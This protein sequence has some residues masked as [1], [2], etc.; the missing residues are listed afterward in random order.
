[1]TIAQNH[2]QPLLI[3]LNN[4]DLQLSPEQFER[5]RMRNP[6]LYLELTKDGKLAVMSPT[7]LE[8]QMEASPVEKDDLQ[9]NS[10]SSHSTDR[11]PQLTP[12]E[13]ARRVAMV[14]KSRHNRAQMWN[15]LTPEERDQSDRQFEYLYQ[16]LEDARK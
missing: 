6:D 7:S 11:L 13:T 16:L 10:S 9:Q 15:E 14:E 1:M 2:P 5:L 4:T 12:E 3:D 8:R